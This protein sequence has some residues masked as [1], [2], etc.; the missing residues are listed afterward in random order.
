[1]SELDLSDNSLT[2]A[3][4]QLLIDFVMES[5]QLS[6]LHLDDNPMIGDV[7]IRTLLEGI[8]DCRSLESLSISNTGCSQTV[9]RVI[10]QV[11]GGC[12][13]LL[14]L[15]ISHC[16]LRQAAIE[17]AAALPNSSTV[18]RVN[19]SINELFYGQRKLA[20]TL[21]ANAARCLTLSRLDLSQNALPSEMAIALFRGL[22]DAPTIHRL[23]I[24]K[25]RAF[26]G[27]TFHIIRS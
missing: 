6:L 24:Q 12:I 5:D 16:C 18:R 27:S 2:G 19:L 8:K 11:L 20:L 23:E 25:C 7:A 17:V 3:V 21:G 4:V 9:G 15:N 26:G 10:A 1:V 13:G 22:G 14:K